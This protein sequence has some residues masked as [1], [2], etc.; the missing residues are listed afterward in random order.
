LSGLLLIVSIVMYRADLIDFIPGH[1][2]SFMSW[3]KSTIKGTAFSDQLFSRRP[4]KPA[5]L[6]SPVFALLMARGIPI[7]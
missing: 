2:L 1:Y 3:S 4:P 6:L 5:L 7:D